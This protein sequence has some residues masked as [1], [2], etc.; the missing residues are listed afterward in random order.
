MAALRYVADG[1]P[2]FPLR[3]R[4]KT[5][6]VKGGFHAATRDPEQVWDWWSREPSANIGIPTGAVSGIDALDVD[7]GGED[8]LAKLETQHGPL[9]DTRKVR[10]GRG[11]QLYFRHPGGLIRCNA[12]A[13]GNGLDFRADGGYVVA[14]PS[15]HPNR[16]VYTS[17]NDLPPADMPTWLVG[18]L[19]KP[20]AQAKSAGA[21][22]GK[23]AAGKRNATLTSIAGNLRRQGLPESEIL[24]SLRG[25]NDRQCDPPLSE[26]EIAT[27]AASV[28]KYVPGTPTPTG[29]SLVPLGEL[30]ARP[31]VPVDWLADGLLAAGTVSAAV[32]KP[33]VCKSTLARNLCWSVARGEPFLGFPTKKGLCVYLVLEER[34]E[35]VIADFRS[36]GA[37]GR[38]D[39]LVHSDTIPAS[40][41]LS[42][43]DLVRERRPALVV[44][45]PLFRLVH[46]KDEK[47]YAESYAALGLLI[48]I[49]RATGTH[50]LV[51]HHAG[52]S[53]KI[54]PVDS[55][56]G[57]TAIA[58][59]V[60]TLI[61]LRRAE[62]YRTIQTVQ[63]IGR[64]LAETVLGFDPATKRLSV[65]GSRFDADRGDC[66][67]RILEFLENASEPQ[68]QNKIRASVEGQTRIIRAAITRLVEAGK[69]T[70]SG[71]G[72]RGNPFV[73][74]VEGMEPVSEQQE[75]VETTMGASNGPTV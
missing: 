52:K 24:E 11:K 38:E 26:S 65:A 4:A 12:G 14:S 21:N 3:P 54:D 13:L 61:I 57:S 33:K 9:P 23:I 37:T 56:L 17:L 48:D 46:I 1:L 6:L 55:P 66:E 50:I 16:T 53:L 41:I 8:S 35:D 60:S 20:K 28:G 30:L 71:E 59:G 69:I 19:T 27:I 2:V 42:L 73:Y 72:T 40:G 64:D 25:I 15:V 70:K 18:L 58:G 22:G 74:G 45:D 63:R 75:L 7:P 5:P 34:L 10:T 49:A 36:M 51:T 31:V 32:S 39:I 43:L 47:S 62:R 29:F 68:T 67:T 44:I